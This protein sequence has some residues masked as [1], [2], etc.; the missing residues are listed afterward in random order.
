MAIPRKVVQINPM[1][2]S[3]V[4]IFE[5]AAEASRV[6]GIGTGHSLI[7]AAC[8][9][10][11]THAGGY[12]WRYLDTFSQHVNKGDIINCQNEQI[13]SCF[14]PF[15]GEEFRDIPGY[16][17]EYK[18]SNFGRV[19]GISKYPF[20]LLINPIIEDNSFCSVSFRQI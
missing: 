20:V 16:E 13:F 17:G 1:S 10:V 5:S 7:A 12:Y 8:R 6:T 4:D 19:I 2:V 18:I 9:G 14:V 15:L 3:V 11:Q